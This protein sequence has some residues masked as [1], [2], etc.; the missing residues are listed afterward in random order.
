[1]IDVLCVLRI[2]ILGPGIVSLLLSWGQ[3]PYLLVELQNI[4]EQKILPLG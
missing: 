3:V 2:R 1:M 4:W